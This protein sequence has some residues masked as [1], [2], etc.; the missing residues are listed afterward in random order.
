MK[1]ESKHIFIGEYLERN[2]KAFKGLEYGLEYLNKVADME[3][4]AERKWKKIHLEKERKQKLLTEILW[5][6]KEVISTPLR[7]EWVS[8]ADIKRIFAKYG[9]KYESPF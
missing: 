2:K 1:N 8:V 4:K 9:I 5:C 7:G 6:S 3:A